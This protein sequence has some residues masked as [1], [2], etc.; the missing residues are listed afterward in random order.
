MSDAP[1]IAPILVLLEDARD[2]GRCREAATALQVLSQLSPE[3]LQV[4]AALARALFGAG[5]WQE[6]WDA[7]EVHFDLMPE[8]FTKVTR[9]GPNGP[10]AMPILRG[11]ALPEAL[12][13]MGEQGLGDT[14]QFAP[15]LPMLRARGVRVHAVLDPRV[16]K[17]LAPVLEGIDAR[18][19]GA[20]GRVQGVKAWLPLLNLPRALGLRPQEYQGRIPYLAAEP[21]RVA[22]WR[23]SIGYQGYLIGIVWQG[24]PQASVDRNRSV[25]ISVFAPIAALRGARFFALQKGPGEDPEAPFALKRLGPEM[26]NSADWFLDTAAA[27]MALDLVV[28]VDTAVLHLAGALGWPALML[29]HGR[30]SDWRWQQGR[31][32]TLWYPSVRLV[33]GPDGNADWRGA[34]E[35]AAF[36]I[37]TGNLPPAA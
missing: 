25:P 30:N 2:A 32:D 34:A 4:K 1:D 20:A 31:E 28:T 19:G 13:V 29:A 17:L 35:G 37:R 16:M 12:M 7:Y 18:P 22:N 27:I 23:Q 21:A 15:F 5:L 9:P 26:D 24:N 10:D 8:V 36:M 6:A 33:R 14:F 3:N 11:G